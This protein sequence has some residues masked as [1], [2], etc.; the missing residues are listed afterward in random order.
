MDKHFEKLLRRKSHFTHKSLPSI[1]EVK[2][3]VN[4]I[5]DRPF[6]TFYVMFVGS[7]MVV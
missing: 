4:Y 7:K 5:P 2:M 1:A 3:L 6:I